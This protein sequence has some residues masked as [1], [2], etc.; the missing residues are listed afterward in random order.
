MRRFL[1]RMFAHNSIYAVT[2][3]YQYTSETDVARTSA[4]V[5]AVDESDAV[6]KVLRSDAK[7]PHGPQ[8]GWGSMVA[9][10]QFVKWC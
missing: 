2:V 4:T 3:V 7:D 8:P 1:Q 10:A 5:K 6:V 9:T